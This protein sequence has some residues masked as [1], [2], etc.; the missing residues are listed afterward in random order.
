MSKEGRGH[1]AA[2]LTRMFI[3]VVALGISAWLR[4]KY[5]AAMTGINVRLSP[6]PRTNSV[7]ASST[8]LV[9][10]VTNAN[11]TVA[12]AMS[13]MP[14]RND[15]AGPYPVGHTPG[16]AQDACGTNA[17]GRHE[18]PGQPGLLATGNLIVQR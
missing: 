18:Q 10:V 5:A 3:V 11:G 15:A 17:L 4:P 8:S 12:A 9:E 14:K 16:P 1:Q 6:R 7:A 2:D 13:T